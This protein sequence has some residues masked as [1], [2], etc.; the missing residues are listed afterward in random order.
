MLEIRQ[1]PLD[2]VL[3]VVPKR[4]GDE[5]GFFTEVWS[6]SRW[7][8][9]GL[10]YD[11]VQDNHSLSRSPHVV[12]GLH[13][14]L[15]PAAQVKLVRVT[16]GRIWDVV[17]DIRRSS[18][19]F[20]QWF[21]VELS[22]DRGNQLLIGAGFAHGFLTLEADCEVQYKVDHGYSPAHDRAVRW[23]DPDLGIEW[24][25]RSAD[26]ILSERDTA[27]PLLNDAELFS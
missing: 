21:G 27:A 16:R 4:I 17:V 22:A 13:Y 8:E 20:R 2:G 18:P 7:A 10:D 6:R 5:R 26:P 3:E 24:P 23:N 25:L 11:F 19:T 9:A 14:Q 1:T 15:P 12:R